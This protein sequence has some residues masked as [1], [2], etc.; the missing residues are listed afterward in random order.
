MFCYVF[1]CKPYFENLLNSPKKQRKTVKKY[2]NTSKKC[3]FIARSLLYK[4][5]ESQQK[6]FLQ[7]KYK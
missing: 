3:R 2:Q 1:R 6:I 7:K 4:D 5:A